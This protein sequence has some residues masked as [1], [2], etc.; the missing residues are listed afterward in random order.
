MPLNVDIPVPAGVVP[1]ANRFTITSW[2]VDCGSGGDVLRVS[3]VATLIHIIDGVEVVDST[4]PLPVRTYVGDS[5]TLLMQDAGAR[6][7]ALLLAGG[8]KAPALHSAIKES[9]YASE[10][11]A[12]NIPAWKLT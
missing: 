12:G 6:Y 2:V 9:L 10:Q 1:M 4:T 7:E 3:S 5:L 11:T 8:E